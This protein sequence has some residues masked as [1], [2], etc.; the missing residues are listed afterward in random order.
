MIGLI[1]NLKAKDN[2][3][4]HYLCCDNAGENIN[5]EGAYKKEM[6]DMDFEYTTPCAP[7][8][9]VLVEPKF[10]ILFNQVCIMLNSRKFSSFL[11]NSY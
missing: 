7:Q 2:I 10:V 8:Q 5:F 1:K 11:R 4:V 6:M 9:N 3:K